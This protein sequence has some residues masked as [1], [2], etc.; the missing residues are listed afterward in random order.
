MACLRF[1][2]KGIR[3]ATGSA[4]F[5]ARI[6]MQ[7]A[8]ARIHTHDEQ[9]KLS[10]EHTH[11]VSLMQLHSISFFTSSLLSLRFG[12]PLIHVVLSL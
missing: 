8:L 4:L 10:K 11:G 1:C 6:R 7:A 12:F 2:E 5:T 3:S 9:T